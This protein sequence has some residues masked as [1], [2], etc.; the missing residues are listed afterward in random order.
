MIVTPAELPGY[1]AVEVFAAQTRALPDLEA[2]FAEMEARGFSV[3]IE[4]RLR[5]MVLIARLTRVGLRLDDLD[6]LRAH[7]LPVLAQSAHDQ[8]EVSQIIADWMRPLPG[9][10][11]VAPKTSIR[12]EVDAVPKQARQSEKADRF[13]LR[14][15][16]GAVAVAVIAFGVALLV[17]MSSGGSTLISAAQE[18]GGYRSPVIGLP[19]LLGPFWQAI[20]EDILSRGIFAAVVLFAGFALLS[21]RS[22]AGSGRLARKFGEASL[23]DVFRLAVNLP[24]WFRTIDARRAFDRLKRSR[25]FD[26]NRIDVA[27]TIAETVHAGGR[28]VVAWDRLRERPNYV[29]IVDRAAREDHAGLFANLLEAAIRDAVV[30]YTRYDFTGSLNR[31]SQVRGATSEDVVYAEVL[32]FSVVASRH[33]GERLI[34]FASGEAFFERPGIRRDRSGQQTIVRRGTPIPELLHIREFG[35]VFLLTPT[36]RPSWGERER[37]LQ[38]LG[39]TVLSADVKGIEAVAERLAL[40]PDDIA[41]S[42]LSESQQGEETFLDRLRRDALRLTSDI[43]PRKPEIA[44]LVTQLK[45]W[46]G[47]PEVYTLLAAIAAFPKIEPAFTIALARF[48]LESRKGE[49][50]SLLYGRLLRLP[51]IRDGRMPD[52]L[53]I[54][55]INGLGERQRELV[56]RIQMF[57]LGRAEPQND[58]APVQS[59]DQLMVSFEV[60]REMPRNRLA[61]AASRIP[62]DAMAADERIFFSVLKDERLDPEQEILQPEA[63]AII[64]ERMEAPERRRLRH[65][66]LGVI[67]LAVLTA[68]LQPWIATA[69]SSIGTALNAVSAALWA[70]IPSPTYVMVWRVL[71]LAFTLVAGG[72]WLANVMR[73]EPRPLLSFPHLWRIASAQARKLQFFTWE[74][75][76]PRWWTILAWIFAIPALASPPGQETTGQVVVLAAMTMTAWVSMVSPDLWWRTPSADDA[77]DEQITFDWITATL[78]TLLV[79][80]LW[81]FPWFSGVLAVV[82]ADKVSVEHV[83][84]AACIGAASW[85]SSNYLMRRWLLGSIASMSPGRPWLDAAFGGVVAIVVAGTVLVINSS[86]PMM[87]AETYVYVA[88]TSSALFISAAT[89]YFSVRSNLGLRVNSLVWRTIVSAMLWAYLIG[90]TL[91]TILAAL[92]KSKPD[93]LSTLGVD[94]ELWLS[95]VISLLNLP[96]LVVF[97]LRISLAW[98]RTARATSVWRI[99]V[100]CVL[101][102]MMVASFI[103]LMLPDNNPINLLSK[104]FAFLPQESFGTFNAAFWFFAFPPALTFWPVFRFVGPAAA[105]RAMLEQATSAGLTVRRSWWVAV[106]TSP[107]WGTLAMWLCARYGEMSLAPLAVPIAVMI[108]WRHGER[109]MVPVLAGTLP[110]LL[111]LR[112]NDAFPDIFS[113]GGIWSI[114]VVLFWAKFTVDA[115]F[116]QQLLRRERLLWAEALL[117]VLLL[118]AWVTMPIADVGT[119]LTLSVNIEPR[120]MLVTVAF[121]IGASR[122]P[123]HRFAL[124][125]VLGYFAVAL[126]W[127]HAVHAIGTVRFGLL[128]G[129]R[130][131]FAALFALYTAWAWRRYA[132]GFRADSD[133]ALTQFEHIR[134]RST[135]EI[136]FYLVVLAVSIFGLAGVAFDVR[137]GMFGPFFAAPDVSAL[138]T[139]G[140]VLGMI[141]SNVFVYRFGPSFGSWVM[142]AHDRKLALAVSSIILLALVTV[143]VGVSK[144]AT[145]QAIGLAISLF[146]FV[147]LGIAVRLANDGRQLEHVSWVEAFAQWWP[148][149]RTASNTDAGT[150]ESVALEQSKVPLVT[151]LTS[152][153]TTRLVRVLFAIYTPSAFDKLLDVYFGMKLANMEDI[154]RSEYEVRQILK[155]FSYEK[156]FQDFQAA[157]LADRPSL[158]PILAEILADPG[159]GVGFPRQP[160][161][162]SGGASIGPTAA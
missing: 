118:S 79:V 19:T 29:L 115:V 43:P 104:L 11:G 137:I 39:L 5:A 24:N 15:T 119:G 54:A 150:R 52:W 83:L 48:V 68:L 160:F 133:D 87:P 80:F 44:R 2:L 148:R 121:A 125:I 102:W 151:S 14:V 77:L 25:W 107:W 49:I 90:M 8:A 38:E 67:G 1:E 136:G 97:A 93:L 123:I 40:D 51:W 144:V 6:K 161:S 22:G 76:E 157:L 31:L 154:E 3:G 105:R 141:A 32:P 149:R 122:M 36:P 98:R 34:L 158:A 101:C 113:P 75:W 110:F 20:L 95:G 35:A 12:S 134:A 88:S 156:K 55:L 153:Q 86:G 116:R 131:A 124:V 69:L 73:H 100:V 130:D 21:W 47:D 71:T 129:P 53:R 152:A 96:P 155:R 143:S 106:A 72:L 82:A 27:R 135:T 159:G 70:L 162:E 74:R 81:G 92:I 33:A 23:V 30:F 132:A 145:G 18:I 91:L 117:V 111:R 120:W 85:A 50:D 89:W 41:S 10:G 140:F 28:P 64:R 138:L 128:L 66:R 9:V 7:L 58:G 16:A 59:L 103:N 147:A 57:M 127:P 4:G 17:K 94:E 114:V 139:A 62:L 78:G 84:I 60:A 42:E 46:A 63:P 109:A 45:A 65:W 126:A 26:T 146:A 61:A 108:A 112:T 13:G 37:L 142:R 99:V 56:R